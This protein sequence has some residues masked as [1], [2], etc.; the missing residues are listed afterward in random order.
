MSSVRRN[1]PPK[2]SKISLAITEFYRATKEFNAFL[3]ETPKSP[4]CPPKVDNVDFL[5]NFMYFVDIVSL[6]INNI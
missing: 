6:L 2:S 5:L 4:R 1:E 3:F